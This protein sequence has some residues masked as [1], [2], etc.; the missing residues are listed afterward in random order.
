MMEAIYFCA[1]LVCA[2]GWWI[3]SLGLRAL[4]LYMK[5]KGYP[6]PLEEE[7]RN[8]TAQIIRHSFRRSDENR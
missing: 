6:E 2:I 5:Q 1:A 7:L 3:R 4:C 8:C